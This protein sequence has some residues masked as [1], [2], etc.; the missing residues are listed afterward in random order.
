MT[1]SIFRIENPV[2][3]VKDLSVSYEKGITAI[4]DINTDI[5]RK[6]ITAIMGPS[7]C[8]KSTLL[9]AFNRMHELY[10]SI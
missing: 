5:E 6:A 4:R 8:G 3:R 10:P 7:G 1:E 2:L 9:R